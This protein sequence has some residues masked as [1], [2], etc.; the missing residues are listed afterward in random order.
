MRGERTSF[1][2]L[3]EN[4]NVVDSSLPVPERRGRS[5]ELIKE[6]NELLVCRHYY[7][8]RIRELQYKRTL[9]K[10]EREVFLSQFTIINIVNANNKLLKAI[11]ADKP[12]V[13]YF[14]LKFPFMV[15]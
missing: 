1:L 13:K 10:L 12:D 9:E 5:E 11:N 2:S 14:R 15:W 3:F 4:D 8:T 7:Y 6:R